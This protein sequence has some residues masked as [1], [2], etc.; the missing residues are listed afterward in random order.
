MRE[1]SKEQDEVLST[2]VA[3]VCNLVK[4][5]GMLVSFRSTF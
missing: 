5:Q 2:I 3:V 1:E 4:N